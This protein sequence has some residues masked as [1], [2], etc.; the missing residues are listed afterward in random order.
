MLIVSKAGLLLNLCCGNRESFED[1]A[2]VG[3]LLHRDD[4]KLVFLIHPNE[5]GL[6]IVVEDTTSLGPFALKTA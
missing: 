5:E 2:D 4:T 1:L 3:A 6:S